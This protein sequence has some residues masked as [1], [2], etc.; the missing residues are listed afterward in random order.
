M[1]AGKFTVARLEQAFRCPAKRRSEVQVG[2]LRRCWLG[3]GLVQEQLGYAKQSAD[4][5]SEP[6]TC[7]L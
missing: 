7:Q 1:H 3:Q 6:G 5:I 4:R 2:R